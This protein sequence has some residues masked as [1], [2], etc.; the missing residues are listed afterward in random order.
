MK[1][2]ITPSFL[3]SRTLY[4]L[5]MKSHILIHSWSMTSSHRDLWDGVKKDVV[6]HAFFQPFPSAFH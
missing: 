3:I 6:N 4:K 5:N 2:V 1:T